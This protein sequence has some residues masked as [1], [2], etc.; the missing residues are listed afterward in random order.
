MS[1]VIV[2]GAG[3][4]G[5]AVAN[6]LQDRGDTAVVL[7]KE[8]SEAR[9]QTGRNSGVIH[10]GLY[11]VPGSLKAT[12]AVAGA[13]SM[14]EFAAKH[15]VEHD[16]CGKLVVAVTDD[17]VPAL[18][19]LYERGQ[20]NGVPCRMIT[21]EEAREYEPHVSCVAALRVESTGIVD[22]KGICSTLVDLIRDSGGE[23]RFDAEV[24]AIAT[25]AAGVTVTTTTGDVTG[26]YLVNCA[27]LYSDRIAVAAGL[28]PEA[29]IIPFR[30]EYFELRPEAQHLVKGLIYPVPDARF[31]FLG[32]HLTKMIEGGVHAGPNAVFAFAREGY[33]WTKINV[34][35]LLLSATWPGLWVLGAKFI[36]PALSETW[37][38]ISRPKFAASL[39]R[40]V[41]AIRN[42]DLVPTHSGVRA[43]AMLRNGAMVDDF[44]FQYAPRQIHVLNAPSPAATAAF[45]IANSI[46]SE[47]AKNR[48]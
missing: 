39:R 1:R 47:L 23:I 44:L 42:A 37:R 27:G 18:Q 3:I 29:R 14:V 45:E 31:P 10:S 34:R 26:D 33:G 7:E 36:G 22:Y 28:R 46:V 21:A 32:V 35:E 24:T 30:G 4:V 20:A 15:G 8:S 2:V 48:D 41:P 6:A 38:S 5:L 43:Q 13:R 12:M 9:H 40:L 17:E 19:K 25:T 11:Y 16:I